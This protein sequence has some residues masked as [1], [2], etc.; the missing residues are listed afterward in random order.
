MYLD[1]NNI[2][3]IILSIIINNYGISINYYN[4]LYRR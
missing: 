4:Q 2:I 1:V 3:V